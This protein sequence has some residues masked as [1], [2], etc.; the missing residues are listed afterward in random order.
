MLKE[1]KIALHRGEVPAAISKL[2]SRVIISGYT[3]IKLGMF[4]GTMVLGGRQKDWF[5]YVPNLGDFV[6][7]ISVMQDVTIIPVSLGNG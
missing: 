4:A 5:A 7:C 1:E 6:V 3:C 2:R